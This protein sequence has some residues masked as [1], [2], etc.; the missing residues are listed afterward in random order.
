MSSDHIRD[1]N[2]GVDVCLGEDTFTTGTFYIKT[3]D[4]EWGCLRP[5]T[6]RGMR[7][8]VVPPNHSEV[9]GEGLLAAVA[10]IGPRTYLTESSI[11]QCDFLSL[12]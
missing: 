2:D 10:A 11:W 12:P 5:L 7:D 3:Q 1:L 8:E 6:V 9:S 4:S